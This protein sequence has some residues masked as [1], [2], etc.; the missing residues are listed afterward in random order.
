[1]SRIVDTNVWVVAEGD[2][3]PSETCVQTCL[4]WL[5]GFKESGERL[6]VDEASFGNEP[7]PG[8]T[9]YKELRRCLSGGSYVHDLFNQHFMKDFFI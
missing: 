3:W 9:V 5:K 6:V 4:D 7:V 1:M 2:S 8:E